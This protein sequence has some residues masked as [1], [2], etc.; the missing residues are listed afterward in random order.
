LF[1]GGN[2]GWWRVT[3]LFAGIFVMGCLRWR[4]TGC[5]LM[6]GK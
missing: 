5:L 3:L 6:R 2:G 1:H 4:I